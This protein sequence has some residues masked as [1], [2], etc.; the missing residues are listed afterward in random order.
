MR[1]LNLSFIIFNLITLFFISRYIENEYYLSLIIYIIFNAINASCFNIL[2]GYAGIISLGQAAFF[3]LGAYTSGIL[4][5]TYGINPYATIIIGIIITAIVAFIIGYPSLKLHGHYLAMATLGFGMIVYICFN[6]MDFITAGPSGLTGIPNISFF[7]IEI[8]SEY[9]F[10]IFLSV[11][12]M[13]FITLMEF[14]DKSFI[15]YKLRFIHES[16][17]A[18]S[19]YGI[20]VAKV[21]LTTFVVI[22]C[23]TSINGS[24]FA[25]YSNF[26]SPVSFSFKY[27]IELVVMAVFGGLGSITGGSI[28]AAILT[29]IPEVFAEIEDYE[30]VI[31]GGILAI[32]ILFFDGGIAKQFKRLVEK[33]VK[34]K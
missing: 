30:M 12:Y 19:S 21:K 22:A 14:F 28:G 10:F 18:S 5:A 25:F 27:S 16:E 8:G 20:N 1:K 6:E 13:I 17:N 26:I 9:K 24:L 34:I 11:F 2:L 31:Y 7:G 15:S 29:F 33:Y 4:S 23:V 3:G 32:T